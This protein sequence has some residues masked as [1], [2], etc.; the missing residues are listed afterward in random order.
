MRPSNGNLKKAPRFDL[1]NRVLKIADT[2]ALFFV[3]VNQIVSHFTDH[4]SAGVLP[5]LL[6]QL[7]STEYSKREIHI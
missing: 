4:R 1:A 3:S 5:I 7:S 6:E 2:V